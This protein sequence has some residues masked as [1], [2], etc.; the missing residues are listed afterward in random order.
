V[1]NE[2]LADS[3]SPGALAGAAGPGADADDGAA[4]PFPAMAGY[5]ESLPQHI[6]AQGGQ[7]NGSYQGHAS[8]PAPLVSPITSAR[9]APLSFAK[10]LSGSVSAVTPYGAK[11]GGVVD[12]PRP[13][14]VPSPLASHVTS[15][16]E[17]IHGMGEH[18][19]HASTSSDGKRRSLSAGAEGEAEDAGGARAS[20]PHGL[21]QP[22]RDVSNSQ[23]A[24][25]AVAISQGCGQVHTG[26]SMGAGLAFEEGQRATA[27]S[28]G[29]GM[30]GDAVGAGA[31][32]PHA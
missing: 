11:G 32:A 26:C 5:E 13:S 27:G 7:Q 31:S 6:Q 25:H 1:P 16:A 2:A 12:Q 17:G 10:A 30:M 18:G 29:Y 8:P 4:H 21:P 19:L 20:L 24:R 23:A 15:S 22:L 3:C 28:L 9:H 14:V